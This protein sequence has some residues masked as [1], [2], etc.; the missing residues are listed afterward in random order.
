MV[1]WEL[2]SH[3][4]A[5]YRRRFT[6]P[7]VKMTRSTSASFTGRLRDQYLISFLF[8]KWLMFGTC[9]H[10]IVADFTWHGRKWT[11]RR[12]SVSEKSH[13][14]TH[15]FSF[16]QIRALPTRPFLWIISA[17]SGELT[18]SDVYQPHT[19]AYVLLEGISPLWFH[20][21]PRDRSAV[22]II[23]GATCADENPGAVCWIFTQTGRRTALT[24]ITL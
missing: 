11:V 7:F 18:R 17:G 16:K 15:A 4:R 12:T 9:E 20:F 8:L 14:M 5:S 10:Q 21:L 1:R 6:F 3:S 24:A 22:S 2:S 19:V 13:F 23:S